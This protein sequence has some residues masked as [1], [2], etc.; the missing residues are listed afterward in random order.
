MGICYE[1]ILIGHLQVLDSISDMKGLLSKKRGQRDT[2]CEKKVILQVS[3]Y[4]GIWHK[5]SFQD[6]KMINLRNSFSPLSNFTHTLFSATKTIT[7]HK[8][9]PDHT[10]N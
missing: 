6:F 4:E 7:K 9:A 10:E 5:S 1:A 3:R 8:S 2:Y